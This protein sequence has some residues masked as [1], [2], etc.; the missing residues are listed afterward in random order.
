MEAKTAI[1]VEKTRATIE[2][3]MDESAIPSIEDYIRIP[4]LSKAY[5]PDWEKN[6]L[7]EKAGNHLL[8]WVKKQNIKG[9]ELKMSSDPGKSPVIFGVMEGSEPN[10]GNI[11]LYGHF[12]KQPHMTGWKEGLSPINPVTI[13]GRL[14]GRGG[15][16]DGYAIYATI[17]AIKACQEQG[18]PLSRLVLLFECDE[19]S[20]TGDLEHYLEKL[21]PQIATPDLIIVLDSGCLNYDQFW[22]TTSLRGYAGAK[23]QIDLLTESV[24]SGNA[25]GIVPSTFRIARQ[26]LDR[27]DDTKTGEVVKAFQV[28]IP[29]HRTKQAKDVAALLGGEL[30]KMF[31]F[32]EGGKPTSADPF[33]CYVNRTWKA[34]LSVTGADGLPPV[35]TAG[36]VLR[37]STT[38]KLSLRLPPTLDSKKAAKDLEEILSKDPPYGAKV[39]VTVGEGGGWNAPENKPYLDAILESASQNFYKK[40]AMAYGEGGTIPFLGFLGRTFPKSQFVVTG[41]LGPNSNAHGPNEFLHIPFTKKLV[42]CMTQVLADVYPHLKKE[43]AK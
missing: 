6:G 30:M 33:E 43:H 2:K 24:H 38:L 41:V 17:L 37:A 1:D 35:Q 8:D 32:V 20:G 40:P 34:Q 22:T 15:A 26:L 14:Y 4:N 18:L 13:D 36:N 31:P 11:L 5:D 19:E 10:S 25:S 3:W 29:A 21:L 9:L 12:D 39:T 42:C 23:V 27:I 28:D 16:D 7:F